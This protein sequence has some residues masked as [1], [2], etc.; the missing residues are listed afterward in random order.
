MR[1][2]ERKTWCCDQQ[3]C[4]EAVEGGGVKVRDRKLSALHHLLDYHEAANTDASLPIHVNLSPTELAKLIGQVVSKDSPRTFT[5]R[6]RTI[7]ATA[8]DP[9]DHQC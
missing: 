2:R 8:P 7:V 1:T 6:N 5:Y 4:V 9:R 3:T